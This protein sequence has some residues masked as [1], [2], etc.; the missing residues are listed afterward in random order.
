MVYMHHAARATA[1]AGSRRCGCLGPPRALQHIC[2]A[3]GRASRQGQGAHHL[4]PQAN[5]ALT[6]FTI[7]MEPS[8]ARECSS[9]SCMRCPRQRND[10]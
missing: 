3:A 5:N 7:A 9:G 2:A 6:L 4:L 10:P 1:H 8:H